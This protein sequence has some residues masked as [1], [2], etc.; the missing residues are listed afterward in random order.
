MTHLRIEISQK[1]RTKPIT[2]NYSD[3]DEAM[4]RWDVA[5]EC[6]VGGDELRLIN[7]E[8]GNVMS[9]Y[10]PVDRGS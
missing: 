4:A 10:S 8:T 3:K 5:T 1:G 6:A 2:L 7:L 9:K